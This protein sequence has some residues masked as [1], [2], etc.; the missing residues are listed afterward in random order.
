MDLQP[1][2][3]LLEQMMSLRAFTKL[4]E[5]VPPM[6]LKKTPYSL[7]FI[8]GSTSQTGHGASCALVTVRKSAD[9]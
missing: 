3:S 6:L 1:R 2:F 8:P 7:G 9:S 5:A 4:P